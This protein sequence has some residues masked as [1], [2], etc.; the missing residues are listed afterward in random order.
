VALVHADDHNINI[1]TNYAHT[2][3]D[4]SQQEIIL[5]LFFQQ[6]RQQKVHVWARDGEDLEH[7]GIIDFVRRLCKIF[8]I[9]PAHVTFHSH[10]KYFNFEFAHEY[11]SMGIFQSVGAHLQENYRLD[12][13]TKFV[14]CTIGR[15][16]PNRFK[17]AYELDQSF[18]S[19]VFLI[20]NSDKYLVQQ[21][22]RA[23]GLNYQEQLAWLMSKKF[24]QDIEILKNPRRPLGA[25]SWQD[26]CQNYH[27]VWSQYQIEVVPETNSLTNYWF[28]EKTARCL[29]TGKPFVIFSGPGSLNYLQKLG[30]KTNKDVLDESYD[31]EAI[32]SKRIQCII[33]SLLELY[34]SPDKDKKLTQLNE[35]AQQNKEF[36]SK[37]YY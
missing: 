35:I 37:T 6:Y 9:N 25:V 34:H 36:F 16:T 15:F 11:L 10:N 18:G 24:D 29:A 5:D 28:T 20:W 17:L 3:L 14:G 8:N 12:Q 21:H 13:P 31:Q 7:I 32:P 1:E 26:S 23:L 27:T 4:L 33:Q 22:Y 30:F 2:S 19:D